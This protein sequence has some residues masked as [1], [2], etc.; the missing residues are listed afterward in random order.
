MSMLWTVFP[1]E[2]SMTNKVV[3]VGHSVVTGEIQF[4]KD[5]NIY[6]MK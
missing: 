6:T 3:C 5:E 1:G 4:P 2:S